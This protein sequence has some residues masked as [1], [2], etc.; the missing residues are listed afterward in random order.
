MRGLLSSKVSIL[1][2]GFH[3]N[4]FKY[5]GPRSS[6]IHLIVNWKPGFYWG[7]Q[8]SMVAKVTRFH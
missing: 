6:E 4:N 5:K 7:N 8:M 3:S 1:R 2:K